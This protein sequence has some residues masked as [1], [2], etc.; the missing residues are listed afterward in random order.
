V[1]FECVGVDSYMRKCSFF[2]PGIY[3]KL[4]ST[5]SVLLSIYRL[6]LHPLASYGPLLARLTTFYGV[7]HAYVGDMHLDINGC[8]GN[9]VCFLAFGVI[10]CAYLLSRNYCEI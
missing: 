1:D 2:Q 10:N 4:I 6:T 3:A 5:Q 7:Y 8:I 9:M